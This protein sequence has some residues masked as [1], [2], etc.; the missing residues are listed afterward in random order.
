MKAN[1][2]ISPEKFYNIIGQIDEIVNV[3]DSD[4]KLVQIAK[5]WH[6]NFSQFC[7]TLLTNGSSS[8]LSFVPKQGDLYELA[9]SPCFLYYGS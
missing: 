4:H 9:R 5:V 6:R 2:L 7:N 1:K 8:L 3:D